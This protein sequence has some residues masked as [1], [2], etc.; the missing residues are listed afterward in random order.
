MNRL[1][2]RARKE[3]RQ[4]NANNQPAINVDTRGGQTLERQEFRAAWF[5]G[6]LPPPAVLAEYNSVLP[7]AADRIIGMAE[8]Q[9]SHRQDLERNVVNG[10]I[11]AEG[12]GQ[13][14]A[15][16]LG[17]I[18]ILGGIGLI[19]LD[20]SSE[21]LVAIVVAFTALA[22]VFIVG[23]YKQSQERKQKR[24]EVER[25]AKEPLLPFDRAQA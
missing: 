25:A 9:S 22:G 21:G 13:R 11:R 15:F 7:G 19:A 17:V 23:R 14:N 16:I 4:A 18:T 3:A 24:E 5:Q 10:N 20:K 6:P 8:R 2:R 1:S 12:V